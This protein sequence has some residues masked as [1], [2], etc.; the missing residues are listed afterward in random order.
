M[1]A[2]RDQWCECLPGLGS[3]SHRV[4]TYRP[5]QV[6]IDFSRSSANQ[7]ILLKI[8]VLSCRT[9]ANGHR[10]RWETLA[11]VSTPAR[12]CLMNSGTGILPVCKSEDDALEAR[13][14]KNEVHS[15]DPSDRS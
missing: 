14:T 1:Q 10:P 2:S 9:I 15:L 7:H 12:I 6:T 5:T 8:D 4:T 11:E 3:S 13:P